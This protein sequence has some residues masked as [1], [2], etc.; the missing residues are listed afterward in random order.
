M[1]DSLNRPFFEPEKRTALQKHHADRP[2]LHFVLFIIT[3]LT[4]TAAGFLLFGDPSLGPGG[5]LIRALTFPAALL[6]ILLAHEMGHYLVARR[7]GIDCSLPYFIPAPVGVGTFGAFIRIRQPIPG[8]QNLLAIGAAGPLAGIALAL[9]ITIAGIWLS[10]YRPITGFSGFRLGD[11][12]GFWLLAKIIKGSAPAGQELYLHPIAFAAWLGFFI[13]SLNL[14]PMSQLDG[15]HVL[16]AMSPRGHALVSR[17]VFIGLIA[18][19]VFGD[20]PAHRKWIF[21]PVGTAL[22]VLAIGLI[23]K[24]TKTKMARNFLAAAA[25]GWVVLLA[26]LEQDSSTVVWVVWGAI[27]YWIGLSHPP[28]KTDVPISR[29]ALVPGWL[30]MIVFILTFIPNPIGFME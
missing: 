21:I 30:C 20:F 26:A 19:G 15:G 4:C 9:P 1:N 18:L 2:Y 6:S 16:Y 10:E 13:T 8:R 17:L 3:I 28:T 25:I 24:P 23:I 14:L 27:A 7:S 5:A 29:Q 22:V 12:L 11:S